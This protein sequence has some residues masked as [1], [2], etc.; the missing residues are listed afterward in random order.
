MCWFKDFKEKRKLKKYLKK[1]PK[2]EYEI[3]KKKLM[4]GE[5]ERSARAGLKHLKRK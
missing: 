5:S 3:Y 1:T 4:R 2:Q